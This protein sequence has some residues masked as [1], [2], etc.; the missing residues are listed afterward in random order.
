MLVRQQAG[1]LRQVQDT[2][3]KAAA[4]SPSSSRSRFLLNTVG[5]QSGS[6]TDSRR[7][8][9]TEGC[10]S[11][12]PQAGVP[13]GSYRR[14]AAAERAAVAR[15][16]SKAGRSR[17]RAQRTEHRASRC[18]I[19]QLADHPQRV[20]FGDPAVRSDIAEE[21]VASLVKTAHFGCPGR[22]DPMY[23]RIQCARVGTRGFSAAC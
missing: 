4:I 18:L 14:L 1:D 2:D 10:S 12:A 21:P 16:V 11:V 23:D 3:M 20:V 17:S 6:S 7:T 19:C 9:G 5:T 8:S 15:A 13:I 22:V